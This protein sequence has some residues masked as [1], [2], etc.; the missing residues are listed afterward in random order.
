MFTAFPTITCTKLRD[1][2]KRIV[3]VKDGNY[4][5]LPFDILIPR[6]QLLE[7]TTNYGF[8]THVAAL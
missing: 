5:Q 6:A 8:T 2:D 1:G 7:G 3:R 4:H